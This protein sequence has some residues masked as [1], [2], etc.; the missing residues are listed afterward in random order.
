MTRVDRL[1]AAAVVVH[2][3]RFAHPV[4]VVLL[5]LLQLLLVK[6][7]RIFRLDHRVLGFVD[8]FS[9]GRRWEIQ[10]VDDTMLFQTLVHL[11]HLLADG[12]H[13]VLLV[14]AP[15]FFVRPHLLLLSSLLQTNDHDARDDGDQRDGRRDGGDHDDLRHRQ[16]SVGCSRIAQSRSATQ[17]RRSRRGMVSILAHLGRSFAPRSGESSRT[18]ALKFIDPVHTST[19]VEAG[20]GRTLVDFVAAVFSGESWLASA[21]IVVD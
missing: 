10:G 14:L 8:R 16:R 7:R 13:H 17:H 19:T 18:D 3:E 12:M 4:D 2:V 6:R 21:S 9:F 11:V 20:S 5:L 1:V 15:S